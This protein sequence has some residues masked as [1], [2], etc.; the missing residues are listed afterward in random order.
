[1]VPVGTLDERTKTE[2]G[3]GPKVFYAVTL[4]FTYLIHLKPLNNIV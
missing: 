2:I 1:M 4:F 3:A